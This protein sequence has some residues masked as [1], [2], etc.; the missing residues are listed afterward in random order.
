MHYK[1]LATDAPHSRTTTP[2]ERL[3]N[4]RQYLLAGNFTPTARTLSSTCSG[5]DAPIIADATSGP[6]Q[7]P[8]QRH[9]RHR[10]APVP[11]Q[12]ASIAPQHQA[13]NLT[14]NAAP[15]TP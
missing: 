6:P 15:P 14:G 12:W 8:R 3:I 4:P 13:N 10:Q 2:V 9:L 5:R 11:Q 1:L 7:H